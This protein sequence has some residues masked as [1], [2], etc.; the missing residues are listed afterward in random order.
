MSQAPYNDPFAEPDRHPSLSWVGAP[1]GATVVGT[2]IDLPHEVQARDFATGKPEEWDDG[3]P[4]WNVVVGVEVNGAKHS[5][6]ALK[7]SALFAAIKEALKSTPPGYMELG[8]TLTITYTGDKP[9]ERAGMN[10]ARQFTAQY[11]PPNAFSGNGQPGQQGQAPASWQQPGQQGQQGQQ[12][13][14]P[15]QWSPA[16]SAPMQPAQND[17]PPF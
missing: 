16:Q 13:S 15:Q 14:P 5:V 2:V 9:P 7:P 12:T 1:P 17:E 11:Q 4:K 10:P 3:N 8:G 6:W